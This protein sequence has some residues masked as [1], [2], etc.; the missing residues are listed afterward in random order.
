MARRNRLPPDIHLV[1]ESIDGLDCWTVMR[2]GRPI[3]FIRKREVNTDGFRP[4]WP[5]G[6]LPPDCIEVNDGCIFATA[7]F[8]YDCE[9]RWEAI[10]S[11]IASDIVHGN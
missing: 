3:G 8:I 10:D 7:E 6:T 9:F 5:W 4:H 11:L 1:R 2:K